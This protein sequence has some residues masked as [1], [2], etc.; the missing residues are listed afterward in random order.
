VH[1]NV[2]CAAEPS[3]PF[4]TD[5]ER[6][7]PAAAF[8]EL[9]GEW[10]RVNGVR[11][12]GAPVGMTVA[13]DGAIW[14]VEDK[15]ATII[16]IDKAA[17]A[18]AETLPCNVRSDRQIDDLVGYVT[19]DNGNRKRLTQLRTDLV[20]KHCS[21]CH[22]E[23]DLKPEQNAEQRDIAALRFILSQDG[24]VYPGDPE[25]GHLRA[26][27]R[28]LGRE[29]V[30]PPD[31]RELLKDAAY[32]RLLDTVDN[33]VATMVPGQRMRV[34]LGRVERNFYDRSGKLCGAIPSGRVV[35][36]VDKNAQEKPGFSRI[37]RP[38]D[39]FL[40]G[41]CADGD[42]YYLETRNLDSL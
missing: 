29:K 1:Y 2:S 20:E 42:V 19:K 21:G 40:N 39:V 35:V 22:S 7:V 27:L 23:F 8:T 26:R 17:D 31:G 9:I 15:N 5:H 25:S 14:L 12:Q 41:E 38:A 18:Q 34:R 37:Y 28:G 36:V 30:M 6:A 32:R 10:H 33:L 16:R 4:Q 13:S 3:R 24:W 11:P